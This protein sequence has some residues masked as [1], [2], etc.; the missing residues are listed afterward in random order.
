MGYTV[1]NPT[2]MQPPPPQP[3]ATVQLN[4]MGHLFYPPGAYGSNRFD[5]PSGIRCCF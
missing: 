4:L 1:P 5:T 2:I 3:V